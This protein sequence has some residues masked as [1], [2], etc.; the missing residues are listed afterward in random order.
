M[1]DT[2]W[3]EPD[4]G[5]EAEFGDFVEL[6]KPRVMR[7]VIF[8]ACVGLLAAPVAVHPVLALAAILCIAVG[9]GAPRDGLIRMQHSRSVSRSRASRS[10]CSGS[11]PTRSRRGCS[12]SRYSSTP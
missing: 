8:T 1:T 4:H 9:A 5:R 7:L 6:L 2:N 3:I 11:W 10:C 12:P